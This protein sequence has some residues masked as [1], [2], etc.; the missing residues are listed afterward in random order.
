MRLVL[1]LLFLAMAQSIL[2]A[3]EEIYTVVMK[4][5]GLP[6]RLSDGRKFDIGENKINEYGNIDMSD[7]FAEMGVEVPKG[8]IIQYNAAS[9]GL[10]AR[11]PKE[12]LELLEAA[13]EFLNRHEN[14][15]AITRAYLSLLGSLSDEER[16]SK[17]L[18]TGFMPDPLIASLIT[19]IKELEVPVIEADVAKK[20]FPDEKLFPEA[21]KTVDEETR[22]EIKKRVAPMKQKLVKLLRISLE[23]LKKELEVID[24]QKEGLKPK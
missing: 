19:R 13:L 2:F 20:L 9:G 1:T 23:R 17:V 24:L 5:D 10:V 12:S 7:Y 16:V 14:H 4:F 6:L 8:S 21:R 3:N 22:A 11:L 18:D 15:V